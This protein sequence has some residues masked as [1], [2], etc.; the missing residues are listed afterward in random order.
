MKH[1]LEAVVWNKWRSKTPKGFYGA[2]GHYGVDTNHVFEE[3]PSPISG[4]IVKIAKQ[5]E[6]GNC[7]YLQDKERG[8]VWVFAHFMTI[9][10]KEGDE[11]TRNTVLGITGNTGSKS[12][13][14]HLHT[15]VIGFT[16]PNYG[17]V[18]NLLARRSL[19]GF[20]GW[21]YDPIATLREYYGKYFINIKGEQIK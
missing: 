1:L 3:F 15:E 20:S 4:K 7:I 10:V 13:S 12:T 11:I 5:A 17:L 19:Q 6:M 14:A 9:L 18:T 8:W 21:S 2:F 16:K